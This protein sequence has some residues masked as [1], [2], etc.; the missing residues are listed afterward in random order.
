MR[1]LEQT[2]SLKVSIL[3]KKLNT[4][5]LTIRRDLD[6]L[7]KEKKIERYHGGAVLTQQ[8]MKNINIFSSDLTLYKHAIARKAASFI[9]DGDTIFIN[10]S[11]TALFM[12]PYIK[13]RQ[14]TIITNSVKAVSS[15]RHKESELVLTGGEIL[16]PKEAMVG[17][18]TLNTLNKVMASKCFL[19]CNGITVEEGVTTAVLQEATVNRQM[20]TRV[21]GKRFILADRTKI[22]RRLNFV[23]GSLSDINCL[24]TDTEADLSEVEKLKGVIEVVRVEP[25]SG[26]NN[27]RN[28]NADGELE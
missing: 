21:T 7:E 18:F 3:A 25:L 16:M 19:G 10:T 23:Y 26:F 24:I 1:L 2:G 28:E 4:S 6:V 8:P 20:L 13:A 27:L 5:Q 15:N 9:E 11:S 12:I 22:G 17:D 14:I